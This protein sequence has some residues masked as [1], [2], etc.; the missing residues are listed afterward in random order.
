MVTVVCV[1]SGSVV[2]AGVVVVS[3]SVVVCAVVDAVV[4]SVL[5]PGATVVTTGSRFEVGVAD[6]VVGLVT[7]PPPEQ[8]A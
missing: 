7:S 2:V 1:V 3:G 5:G 8:M 4:V 6:V